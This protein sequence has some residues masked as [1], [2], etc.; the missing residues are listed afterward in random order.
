MPQR[1]QLFGAPGVDRDGELHALPFERRSQLIALLALRRRW[2]PRAEVAALLW[3][4]Q[5]PRQAYSNLRSTLFRLPKL[6]SGLEVESEA[7]A[8]RCLV[9]TDVLDFDA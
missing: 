3:P 9:E 5:Q 4:E 6:A 1:L 7:E 8:L 2:L